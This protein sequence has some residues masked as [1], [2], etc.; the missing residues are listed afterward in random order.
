M[1]AY[2]HQG[3]AEEAPASTLYAIE[4]A[5]SAGAD[6]IELDVHATADGEIVV[7]H[8]ATLDATTDGTGPI[9]ERT[10]AEIAHLDA[11]YHF[12]PGRGSVPGR[13]AGEYPLRHAARRDE[14]LRVP[15]LAEVLEATRGV[16]LN[17][18]IKQ[19]APRVRPYEAALVALLR[20]HGRIEDV[21]VASFHEAAVARVGVLAPEIAVSPQRRALRSFLLA[22]RT[23]RRPPEF[24][25]R[26]AAFQVPSHVR[27]IRLVT[28]GFVATAHEIGVA[29]HAWTVNDPAEMDRLVGAGVDGIMTDRPSVLAAR[30]AHLGAPRVP[31]SRAAGGGT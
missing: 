17:L 29:V 14:R 2:A 25:S 30:L 15:R 31:G 27:G 9:A 4:H 3:G 23:R 8:D 6:A 1:L 19:T 21:I 26:Y 28:A 18:D 16:P 11:A 20:R 22:Q 12:I 13:P 7:C 24:L 5:L 10:Y